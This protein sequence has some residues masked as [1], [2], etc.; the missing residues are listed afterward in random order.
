[1]KNGW[2]RIRAWKGQYNV[3][4]YGKAATK[5]PKVMKFLKEAGAGP[6]TPILLSDLATDYNQ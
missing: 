6:Y 3:Q 4:L 5:L 1:M 2:V